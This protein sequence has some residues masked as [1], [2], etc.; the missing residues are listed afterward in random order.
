VHETNIKL[1]DFWPVHPTRHL[2]KFLQLVKNTHV[3]NCRFKN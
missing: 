2:A 3:L 1:V